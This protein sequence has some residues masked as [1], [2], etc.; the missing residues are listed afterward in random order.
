[1]TTFH[2]V[3]A[4]IAKNEAEFRKPGVISVRPGYKLDNGWPVGDPIIV[5]SVSSAHGGLSLTGLPRLVDGVPVE[6]REASPTHLLRTQ[7]PEAFAALQDSALDE[8]RLPVFPGEVDFTADG[9]SMAASV[10]EAAAKAKKP[11]IDY[12]G[13]P[14]KPLDPVTA[15]FQ[16]TCHASPDAG[17]PTLKDFFGRIERTLTVG[18]YDFTSAHILESVDEVMG[19]GAGKTLTLVLD[20]PKKNPTADQTDPETKEKL[21]DTLTGKW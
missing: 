19:A 18:L 5:A 10:A 17:W 8:E 4:T 14:G 12:T 21:A 11:E 6:L 13:V 3:G 1:M 9:V 2:E 20:D 7:N 16:L 15:T